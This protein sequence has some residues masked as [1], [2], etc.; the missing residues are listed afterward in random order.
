MFA[1]AA[2]IKAFPVTVLPYLL[3]RRRWRAA[4]SMTTGLVILLLVVPG[5]IR[6][7][8]RNASELTTWFTGMVLSTSEKGF[9]Q[10]ETQNWGWRN[11]SIIAVTHRLLRPVDAMQSDPGQKP[12]YLN[13]LSLSCRQAN[14]ALMAVVVL[15]GAAFCA[16]LPAERRRTPRSDAAEYSLLLCLMIIASPLARVYYFVW[17]LFPIT[18]LVYRAALEQRA[19]ERWIAAVMLMAALALF[20]IAPLLGQPHRLEAAGSM[21]W[22][23]TIIALALAWALRERDRGP[24]QL[25]RDGGIFGRPGGAPDELAKSD[26]APDGGVEGIA[27]AAAPRMGCRRRMAGSIQSPPVI[28]EIAAGRSTM[29][30]ATIIM[31]KTKAAATRVNRPK[32]SASPP[33]TSIRPAR[34][35]NELGRPSLLSKE[36]A[37]RLD[38]VAAK[39]AEQLLRPVRQ[40]ERAGDDA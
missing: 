24:E 29:I 10:R 19:K 30:T 20:A 15:I 33:T 16:V 1:L 25:K 2:A 35:A 11:S 28:A 8:D 6:G 12:L 13:V 5:P 34:S 38:A 39:P 40:Q 31:T 36:L 21:F 3:W 14:L 4:A 18:T 17:L 23:T 9:G 7:F 22:A 32:A 26:L 37:G 27:A